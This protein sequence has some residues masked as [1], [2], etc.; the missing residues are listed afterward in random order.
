[1]HKVKSNKSSFLKASHLSMLDFFFLMKCLCKTSIF[2]SLDV[3]DTSQLLQS[4]LSQ[5]E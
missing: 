4:Q 3:S 2:V 1:M 5:A